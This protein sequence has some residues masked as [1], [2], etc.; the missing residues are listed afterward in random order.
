MKLSITQE[1]SDAVLDELRT[2]NLGFNNLYPGELPDRQPVHT[3]YGGANLFKSDTTQK[4]GKAALANLLTYA[5]NFT[6]L[7]RVLKLS[8]S[9]NLPHT[10]Q[11][12]KE[13]E[14]KLDNLVDSARKKDPAWLAHTVYK[15]IIYT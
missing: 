2:Y 12:I 3:V 9:D 11:R 4:M 14:V 8:N 15:K 1:Q 7:A 6:V 10:E 5:P 13:L